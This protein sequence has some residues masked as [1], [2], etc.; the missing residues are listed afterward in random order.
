MI[1]I[2]TPN[3]HKRSSY[4]WLLSVEGVSAQTIG[5]GAGSGLCGRLNSAHSCRALEWRD[6]RMCFSGADNAPAAG[7][8]G[9]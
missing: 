2:G 4:P 5:M 7:Q 8:R 6:N 9:A 3:S 1:G